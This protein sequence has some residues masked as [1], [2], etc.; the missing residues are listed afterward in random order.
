MSRGIDPVPNRL[1]PNRKRIRSGGRDVTR[2]VTG[3]AWPSSGADVSGRRR[4]RR[5]RSLIRCWPQTAPV[6][7]CSGVFLSTSLFQFPISRICC[8]GYCTIVVLL[9]ALFNVCYGATPM[10]TASSGAHRRRF[11]YL[12][13][14]G[15]LIGYKDISFLFSCSG[16]CFF[17]L[18]WRKVCRKVCQCSATRLLGYWVSPDMRTGGRFCNWDGLICCFSLIL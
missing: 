7:R 2:L 8:Q 14:L 12:L 1:E 15:S 3:T 16:S 17:F 18:L 4:R 10:V 13:T 5:R 9:Y 6:A 11:D